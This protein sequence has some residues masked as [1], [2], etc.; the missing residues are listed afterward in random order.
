MPARPPE[1]LSLSRLA[2][3]L[4]PALALV[5]E[6]ARLRAFNWEDRGLPWGADGLEAPPPP[7]L[8]RAV[9]AYF[10]GELGALDAIACAWRGTP[11]QD[12][13]WATLRTIPSGQTLTYAELAAKLGRPAAVRATGAANGA[14]PICLVV[15]CHRVIGSS[16]AL[17]GYGGGLD[18]KRWLLEHERAF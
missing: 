4:G 15:P 2:T 1:R 7:A 14:N 10:E 16:G 5:D 6:Q 13:V 3:P 11:F 18:R 9:E 17:T 8:R 12:Q